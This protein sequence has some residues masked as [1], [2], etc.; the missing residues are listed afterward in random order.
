MSPEVY[1]FI[2]LASVL[3]LFLSMGGLIIPTM[4]G[5]SEN[6]KGGRKLAMIC[7]GLAMFLVLVAGFGL[8]AKL[9]YGFQGW[10]VAKIMIWFLIGGLLI[11][12]KRRPQLGKQLWFVMIALAVAAAYL[13]GFKPF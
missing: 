9:K 8:I 12:I 3:V 13:A 11:I 7:H 2:H 4:M 5:P 6:D 1:R 10:V